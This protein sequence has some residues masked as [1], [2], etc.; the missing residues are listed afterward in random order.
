MS[1]RCQLKHAALAEISE[2]LTNELV[3]NEGMEKEMQA[4]H[5]KDPVPFPSNH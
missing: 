1:C 3:W 4:D 5:S 2:G